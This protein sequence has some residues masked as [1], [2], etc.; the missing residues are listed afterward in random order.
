MWINVPEKA[1]T[2]L[3]KM[4][5]ATETEE[6]MHGEQWGGGGNDTAKWTI[7]RTRT[8]KRKEGFFF[9]FFFSA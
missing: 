6:E 9:G 4:K 7:W 3:R 1:P 8:E 5:S 2:M